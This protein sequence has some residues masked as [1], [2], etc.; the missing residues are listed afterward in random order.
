MGRASYSDPRK[1]KALND[2]LNAVRPKASDGKF[3]HHK[4]ASLRRVI[5]KEKKLN[6]P[7]SATKEIYTQE[8][9]T[10][11]LLWS[12]ADWSSVDTEAHN[13]LCLTKLVKKLRIFDDSTEK[14]LADLG[15]AK[16]IFTAR[17]TPTGPRKPSEQVEHETV[18]EP[19]R[20]IA[21]EL[22]CYVATADNEG[23]PDNIILHQGRLI[24][25]AEYKRP[26]KGYADRLQ[27]QRVLE[28]RSHDICAHIF[29]DVA[30]FK[31]RLQELLA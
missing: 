14:L 3:V 29:N 6:V 22:G 18:A 25:F 16:R 24:M 20:A 17:T 27:K 1:V 30:T 28:L 5:A 12:S 19:C 8:F 10:K 7:S 23:Y 21:R 4:L 15:K 9:A 11:G 26:T 13:R 31:T 2:R